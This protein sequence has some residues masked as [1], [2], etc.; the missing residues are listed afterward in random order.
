MTEQEIKD[1]KPS[2]AT[3]YMDD[4]KGFDYVRI[5]EDRYMDVW[6]SR[7]STWLPVGYVALNDRFKPL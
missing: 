4:E 2:G 7:F 3:H 1:S 6:F 5:D